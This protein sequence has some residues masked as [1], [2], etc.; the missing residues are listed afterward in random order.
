MLSIVKTRWKNVILSMSQN[1][2]VE[3]GYVFSS[4]VSFF[5]VK[6]GYVFISYGTG[7]YH[8]NMHVGCVCLVYYKRIFQCYAWIKLY[9]FLK[10]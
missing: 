3:V 1:K 7:E 2:Y 5:T 10:L 6:E 8:K 4:F 9:F